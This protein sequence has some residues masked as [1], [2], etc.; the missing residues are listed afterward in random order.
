MSNILTFH[1]LDY[2]LSH[3][4][5]DITEG[6][7]LKFVTQEAYDALSPAEKNND[8]IEYHITN[9]EIQ[10]ISSIVIED[11]SLKLLDKD[12]IVIGNAVDLS[13]ISG[14]GLTEEQVN[15]INS[16]SS[17]ETRV[18]SLETEISTALDDI[19]GEVI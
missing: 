14:T 12:G 6:V 10:E 19:N 3:V 1:Q 4:K 17:L 9:K 16:I 8:K 7:Q 18:S 15:A 11:N 13:G 5:N 2:I